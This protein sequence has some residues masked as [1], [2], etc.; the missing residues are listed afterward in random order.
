[1]IGWNQ[2]RLYVWQSIFSF[3]A[4]ASAVYRRS[5]LTEN[6]LNTKQ[7]LKEFYANFGCELSQRFLQYLK[8]LCH[9]INN[10]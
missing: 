8:G 4:Q 6:T 7:I 10:F 2:G 3:L 9:K 1:M 5:I